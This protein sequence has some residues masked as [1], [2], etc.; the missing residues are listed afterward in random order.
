MQ[1][2]DEAVILGARKHGESSMIVEAMTREHGRHFGL[3]RGGRSAR[4]SALLQPGNIVDVTWRARLDEHLGQ[5][6]LEANDLRAGRFLEQAASLFGLG[7]ITNL[8][9]LMAEREAHAGIYAAL[10]VVLEHLDA[11]LIAAPLIVRFE[12]ALLAELGFG[13][14]LNACAVTGATQELIYVSPKSGRAVSRQGGTAYADRLLA[15]PAFVRDGF[16]GDRIST[17]EIVAGFALTGHF[18]ARDVYEPRGIEVPPERASF[19]AVTAK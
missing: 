15:L 17:D 14:D 13:L 7:H 1:W 4:M 9:R 18:L 11:P 5:F 12:L 10:L 2:T 16:L 8:T 3:V 6:S 19:I